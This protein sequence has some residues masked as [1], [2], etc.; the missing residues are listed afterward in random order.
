MKI[1]ENFCEEHFF[2]EKRTSVLESRWL[3]R[4]VLEIHKL[5]KG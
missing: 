2:G 3:R 1:E 4:E 5:M